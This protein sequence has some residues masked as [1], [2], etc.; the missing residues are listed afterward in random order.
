[1]ELALDYLIEPIQ[2]TTGW[3]GKWWARSFMGACVEWVG[4]IN[5]SADAYGISDFGPVALSRLETIHWHGYA[6]RVPPLDLQLAVNER[7]GRDV[8]A[9]IIRKALIAF[10]V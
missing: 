1:G 10:M 7:R 8:T 3:I 6:I 4:G 2:E 5:D 9:A